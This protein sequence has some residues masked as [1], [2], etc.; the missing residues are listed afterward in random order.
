MFKKT[1]ILMSLLL[2]A[3][4]AGPGMGHCSSGKHSCCSD[5]ASCC[6]MKDC[7]KGD[8]EAM[9]PMKDKK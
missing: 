2:A 1:F 5:K 7:C 3:A 8:G 9:C 4:C 6:D